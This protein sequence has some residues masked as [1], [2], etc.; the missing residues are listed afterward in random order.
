V[1]RM[2]PIWVWIQIVTLVFILAGM[3]IAIIKL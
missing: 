3:V 1:R 2:S